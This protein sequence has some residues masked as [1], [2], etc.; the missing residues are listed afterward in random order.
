MIAV[1]LPLPDAANFALTNRRLSLLIGP[2]Y[3]PRLRIHAV[4]PKHRQ[5]FLTTFARDIPSWF[6]CHSCMAFVQQ[7]LSMSPQSQ[8]SAENPFP[9]GLSIR[10]EVDHCHSI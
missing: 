3:W 6:Y 1:Q 9:Q 2:I 7:V 10:T 8:H 5:Q 4:T